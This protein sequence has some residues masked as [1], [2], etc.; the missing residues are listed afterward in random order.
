MVVVPQLFDRLGEASFGLLVLGA[1]LYTL[2]ATVYAGRRP[3]RLIE[4]AL[5]H[6]LQ[7]HLLGAT[8]CTRNTCRKPAGAGLR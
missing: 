7:A 8:T 4:A 6:A 3:R 2:G 5:Q 1:A